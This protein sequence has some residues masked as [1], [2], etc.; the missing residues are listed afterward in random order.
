[1]R[2]CVHF[3]WTRD[4]VGRRAPMM[5]FEGERFAPARVHPVPP[6]VVEHLPMVVP[7]GRHAEVVDLLDAAIAQL[8]DRSAVADYMLWPAL[9]RL[10]ELARGGGRRRAAGGKTRRAVFALKQH[11]ESH[12]RAPLG[13]DEFCRRSR[14]SAAHLCQGFKSLIGRPP[15]AYLLDVRLS[16]ARRLLVESTLN[17]AEVAR[18]V[19]IPDPNYFSRLF[20]SRLGCSP[21]EFLRAGR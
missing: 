1:M 18:E 4:H 7:L 6:W 21:T 3:D 20:R 14:L 5:C 9:R 2:Y 15:V 10:V 8:R 11:I 16:H 13:Y 17:I 12:Y 19:G